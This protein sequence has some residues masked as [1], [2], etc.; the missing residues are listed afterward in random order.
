M[1]V[2]VTGRAGFTGSQLVEWLLKEGYD[3]IC[4][5]I[6]KN[7]YNPELKRNNVR[8]FLSERNFKLV[9]VNILDKDARKRIF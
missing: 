3:V 2:L 8:P 1:K 4:L 5:D 9:E 7:Y 6:F